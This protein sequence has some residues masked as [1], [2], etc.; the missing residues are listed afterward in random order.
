[1]LL[2]VEDDTALLESLRKL[3]EHFFATIF[4]ATNPE[5]AL[6]IYKQNYLDKRFL[7]MSDINLGGESGVDLSYAIRTLYKKQRIIAISASQ[8]S[9]VFIDSIECGI[10]RFLLIFQAI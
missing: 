8:E 10:D 7:V 2:L 5:D 1:V 4:T 3:L 9:G 6:A